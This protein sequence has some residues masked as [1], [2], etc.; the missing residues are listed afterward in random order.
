MPKKTEMRRKND[1]LWKSILEEVFDDF[2]RFA[3]PH[4]ENLFALKETFGFLDK[5]LTKIHSENKPDTRLVDKLVK[6]PRLNQKEKSTLVHVEVQDR[7]DPQLPQRMFEYHS[8]L[9]Y[10]HNDPITAIAIFTGKN[11][12]KSPCYK[13]HH[14]GTAT[15]YRFN[16]LYLFDFTDQELE[17][18][19]NPFALVLLIAKKAASKGKIPDTQLLEEKLSIGRLLLRRGLFKN[20]KLQKICAF[21]NHYI[22]FENPEMNRTFTQRF[23]T[24]TKKKNTMGIIEALAIEARKEARR[25]G[26]KE[27]RQEGRQESR[28]E[29]ITNMLTKS[30]LSDQQIADLTSVSLNI[31]KKMRSRLK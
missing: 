25:E 14:A 15:T 3:I 18:H 5:E 10:L 22:Q 11:P 8:R 21:L 2:L 6:V 29:I 13:H 30:N 9:K 23:D 26:L 31:I 1:I 27:G 17:N 28:E 20:R 16:A 7:N 19:P 24:L 4:A 12:K